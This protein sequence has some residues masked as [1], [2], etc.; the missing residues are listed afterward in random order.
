[1]I[2][3]D[4]HVSDAPRFDFHCCPVLGIRKGIQPKFLTCTWK[5]MITLTEVREKLKN[6][7][8]VIIVGMQV[9][10]RAEVR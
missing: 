2:K 9:N 1:M 10:A 6:S 7:A 5:C 8:V 4:K 3:E